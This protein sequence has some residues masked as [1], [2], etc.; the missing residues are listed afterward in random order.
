MTNKITTKQL[1][2]IL[3]K[4]RLQD[5]FSSSFAIACASIASEK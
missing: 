2:A 4:R 5:A 3:A 1:D